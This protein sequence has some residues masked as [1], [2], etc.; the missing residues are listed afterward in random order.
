MLSMNAHNSYHGKKDIAGQFAVSRI[1][2]NDR[3]FVC[4][5]LIS[6][7]TPY[8]GKDCVLFLMKETSYNRYIQRLCQHVTTA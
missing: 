8:P 7:Q 6:S 3:S 4:R 5:T 2:N 1:F